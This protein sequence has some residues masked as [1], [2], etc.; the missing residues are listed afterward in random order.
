MD[1]IGFV[2]ETCFNNACLHVPGTRREAAATASG[3]SVSSNCST[4]VPSSNMSPVSSTPA[5]RA[6]TAR[7][8]RLDPSS[9]QLQLT[10]MSR[11]ACTV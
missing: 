2:Q 1:E 5:G 11:N 4:S 9:S 8:T 3:P 6:H 7:S 10:A